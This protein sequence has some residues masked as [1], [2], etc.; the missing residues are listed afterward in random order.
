MNYPMTSLFANN[1]CMQNYLKLKEA[2]HVVLRI[3]P[4]LALM[5][6]FISAGAQTIPPRPNPPK[7][8]NDFA[9]ILSNAERENLEHKLYQYDDSTSNQIAIIIINSLDGNDISQ[10]TFSTIDKWGIG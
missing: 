3:L 7:L 6:I 8:V 1:G 9:G 4:A 5:L 2:K 10:L